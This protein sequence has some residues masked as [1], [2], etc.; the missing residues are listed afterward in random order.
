MQAKGVK[1]EQA[2]SKI[3]EAFDSI[4]EY[5][6]EV[7]DLMPRQKSA[8]SEIKELVTQVEQHK[9][10][11]IVVSEIYNSMF[12]FIINKFSIFYSKIVII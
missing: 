6:R 5:K 9:Q 7:S 11:Y 4:K 12:K 8:N 2:L 1:F 3:D 10:D